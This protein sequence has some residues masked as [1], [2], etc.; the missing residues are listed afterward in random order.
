MEKNI[1]ETLQ[2]F[3]ELFPIQTLYNLC[4]HDCRQIETPPMDEDHRPPQTNMQLS[5]LMNKYTFYK[6]SFP[7]T[8]P[9]NMY[10]YIYTGEVEWFRIVQYKVVHF[11]AASQTTIAV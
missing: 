10:M 5:L 3:A 11:N 1:F 8:H 6:A 9:V 7:L 2:L 4:R